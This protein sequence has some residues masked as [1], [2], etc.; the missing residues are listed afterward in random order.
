MH[1]GVLP[2]R[3]LHRSPDTSAGLIIGTQ[4]CKGSAWCR[5]VLEVACDRAA[6]GECDGGAH[7]AEQD[8]LRPGA[9]VAVVAKARLDATERG[10]CYGG[11]AAGDQE[12]LLIEQAS[13]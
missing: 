13:K 9:K 4:A 10:Q 3:D 8:G 5:S 11:D 7:P 1:S 2:G 12:E 6:H